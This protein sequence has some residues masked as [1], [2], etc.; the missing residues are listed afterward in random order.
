MKQ[1]FSILFNK[2][3]TKY[4]KTSLRM[5]LVSGEI[6]KKHPLSLGFV[7]QKRLV[8]VI[9]LHPVLSKVYTLQ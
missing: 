4:L 8:N 7:G 1:I 2:I 9:Y 5:N 6:I 3:S